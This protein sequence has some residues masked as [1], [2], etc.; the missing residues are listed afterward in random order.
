MIYRLNG[1]CSNNQAKQ[2]AILK[3]LEKIQNL[4]TNEK[5]AQIFRQPDNTRRTQKP[6]KPRAPHRTNKDEGD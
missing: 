5:N 1:R 3:T 6:E 2:L 4:D